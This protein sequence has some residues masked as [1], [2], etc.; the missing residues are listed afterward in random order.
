[1]LSIQEANEIAK[2]VA[3]EFGVPPPPPLYVTTDLSPK[4]AGAYYHNGVEHIKIRPQYLMPGTVAHEVGHYIFHQRAPGV[5]HGD[6]PEC[7]EI[8]RMIEKWYVNYRRTERKLS[9]DYSGMYPRVH[10]TIDAS[11]AYTCTVSVFQQN[12]SPASFAQLLVYRSAHVCVLWWCWNIDNYYETVS[13]DLNG[14]ATLYLGKQRWHVHANWS[15]QHGDWYGD[16]N[17]NIGL[18]MHLRT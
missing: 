7:E 1:M 15:N 12:G 3:Q 11:P 8:A 14:K 6:N 2:Q 18:N 4:Y 16:V 10:D 9:G 17:S 5:C 13:A